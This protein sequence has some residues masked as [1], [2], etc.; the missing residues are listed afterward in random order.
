[1][2]R[3]V[4]LPSRTQRGGGGTGRPAGP[5]SHQGE[6]AVFPFE[7]PPLLLLALLVLGVLLVVWG[8]RTDAK[9]RRTAR[10]SATRR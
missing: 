10:Q 9:Q 3:P 2:S 5:P 7:I 8:H 6:I 1:M 4:P